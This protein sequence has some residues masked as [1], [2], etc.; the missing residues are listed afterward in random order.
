MCSGGRRNRK[1]A[2][3]EVWCQTRDLGL[4][5]AAKVERPGGEEERVAGVVVV[6][7]RDD[8]V[9]DRVRSEPSL[10]KHRVQRSGWLE[11]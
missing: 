7:V 9:L 11:G 8:C 3:V 4:R 10:G 2:V 6:D 5:V 1:D